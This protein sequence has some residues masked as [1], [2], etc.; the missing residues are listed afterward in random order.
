M[1]TTLPL[2]PSEVQPQLPLERAIAG[3]VTG[4]IAEVLTVDA[5]DRIRRSRMVQHIRRIKPDLNGLAFRDLERLAEIRIKPDR[6]WSL[7]GSLAEIP[8]PAGTWIDQQILDRV[9]IGQRHRARR[10]G[11][12]FARNRTEVAHHIGTSSVC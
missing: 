9:A 4:E 6:P 1:L 3:L 7:D 5:E 11:R 8:L 12:H 2:S 10:T